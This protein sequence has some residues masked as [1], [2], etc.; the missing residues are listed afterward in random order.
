MTANFHDTPLLRSIFTSQNILKIPFNP[1]HITL[2]ILS[3]YQGYSFCYT[4]GSK[5]NNKVAYAFR[6]ASTIHSHLSRNSFSVFSAEQTGNTFMFAIYSLPHTL[7][8]YLTLLA[9]SSLYWTL[10]YTTH[11][12]TVY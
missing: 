7:Y 8:K 6:I 5:T 1:I 11:S 9:L 10:I 2:K 12:R 4:D 3:E